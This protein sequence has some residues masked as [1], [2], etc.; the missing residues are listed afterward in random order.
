[1]NNSK[2][3]IT[4]ED[5]RVALETVESAE[6]RINQQ[7]RN[8]PSKNG[9]ISLCFGIFSCAIAFD[10]H[11]I[12]STVAIALTFLAASILLLGFFYMHKAGVKVNL[13]PH[14]FS[15]KVLSVGMMVVFVAVMFGAESFYVQGYL[16]A[17]YLAGIVNAILYSIAMWKA[18]LG[19]WLVVAQ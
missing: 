15:G 19:E 14:S 17:P 6:S 16:W 9:I 7:F 5:A 3:Q 4:P 11:A 12:W 1:M 8:P 10:D 13:L 18:P 2:S